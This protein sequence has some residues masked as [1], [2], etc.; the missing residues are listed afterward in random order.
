VL[1]RVEQ[2]VH[3]YGER[4]LL[5]AWRIEALP[6][7]LP[8]SLGAAAPVVP[9]SAATA[10]APNSDAQ[11]KAR[12]H[13]KAQAH[14]SSRSLAGKR[15][16]IVGS[17]VF[18]LST[19]WSLACRFP[20]ARILVLEKGSSFPDASRAASQDCNRIVRPDYGDDALYTAWSLESMRRWKRDFNELKLRP[21][22][23]DKG[24]KAEAAVKPHATDDADPVYRESGVVF[25]AEPQSM[26]VPKE[27]GCAAPV[28]YE[29][30]S[31]RTMQSPPFSLPL[32]PL[33]ADGCLLREHFPVW[34]QQRHL[35]SGYFNP[36]GGHVDASR[37]MYILLQRLRRFHAS[38]VELRGGVQVVEV[39]SE[40]VQPQ[41]QPQH[42]SSQCQQSR[43]CTGVR[44]SSGE[45]IPA[46]VVIVAA[47]CW[48]PRVL[49]ELA[50]SLRASAQ[51]VIYVRPRQDRIQDNKELVTRSALSHDSDAAAAAGY[52]SIYADRVPQAI[53]P[54]QLCVP[55]G[56]AAAGAAASSSSMP[57][58]TTPFP[59]FSADLS[60]SGFYGFPLARMNHV[61]A[62]SNNNSSSSS[63]RAVKI[64]HHGPG[65][66]ESH[67][68]S[69]LGPD[70]PRR[71][72]GALQLASFAHFLRAH[73]PHLYAHGELVDAR[74][75][76]YSDSF[77]GHWI[78][79]QH[80][81]V[82]GAFVASGDSGHAFKFLPLLGDV[83]GQSSAMRN[84][85]RGDFIFARFNFKDR[86]V[87]TCLCL[88]CDVC[89]CSLAS[90]VCNDAAAAPFASRFAWRLPVDGVAPQADV[91]RARSNVSS[92]RAAASAA[93]SS[94]AASGV[95]SVTGLPAEQRNVSEDEVNTAAPATANSHEEHDE[96]E[97]R[98]ML[99]RELQAQGTGAN[100]SRFLASV[101][102]YLDRKDSELGQQGS[103]SA[104]S[105]ASS[106]SA[107][108]R[109]KL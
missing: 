81:H 36:H 109:A 73:L 47:G 65:V 45:T 58:S 12:A 59:V 101:V 92:T 50:P 103:T 57:L 37:A 85:W 17:G 11:A 31:M 18:G 89:V 74:T 49:P 108:P 70:E 38:R 63:V 94:A 71:A 75:C 99:Q 9:V 79:G 56:V 82:E 1:E 61:A 6:A 46:D 100:S 42:P 8:K 91:C 10:N 44:T 34:S 27:D 87:L 62:S 107:L 80:P 68:R 35:T 25:L 24:T 19:A 26:V 39:L 33:S 84:A 93:T 86:S 60:R 28:P 52:D 54:A 96:S 15:V 55:G 14:S 21:V 29:A 4:D 7:I 102:G 104:A 64:G 72:L 83:V 105:S 88:F 13:S 16:V 22:Q 78:I 97:A 40:E 106:A 69:A 32:L 20:S 67:W 66:P 53:D 41:Q 23:G 3:R 30:A 77:D 98:R 51:P 48:T 43:R 90:I 2:L 5:Q 95:N 76:F